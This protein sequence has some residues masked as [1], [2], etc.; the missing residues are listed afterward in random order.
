MEL[1]KPIIRVGNSAGVLLP[2]EWLDG[3]AKVELISKPL[4]IKKD[5]FDILNEYFKDIIGIY[6]AGSYARREENEK[7]DVDVLVI[8]HNLNKRIVNGKYNIILI[9]KDNLKTTLKNNIIPLL[10]MVI[11]SKPIINGQLINDYKNTKLSKENLKWH[12]ETTKSALNVV[13]GLFDLY[14]NDKKIDSSVAYSLVLRLREIYIVDCLIKGRIW[15]N[16]KL[17]STI[18]QITGSRELYDAYLRVKNSKQG[19]RHGK[20]NTYEAKTLYNYV[21]KKLKRHEEW[22]KRR[23]S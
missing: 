16:K 9:S 6:L 19:Y 20:I 5:I 15:S 13:S 11:E 8:T 7:S 2:K 1:I 21:I 18:K 3:K 12:L 14:K 22:L 17:I 23:K 10:P 4:D